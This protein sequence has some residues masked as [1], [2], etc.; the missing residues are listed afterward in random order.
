MRFQ[1]TPTPPAHPRSLPAVVLPLAQAN[2]T[3]IEAQNRPAK[4]PF[5]TINGFHCVG[6]QPCVC[7]LPPPSGWGWQTSAAKGASG[8]PSLT[9][10][11]SRPAGP[12]RLTLRTELLAGPSLDG[13]EEVLVVHSTPHSTR[14]HP[15]HRARN[16]GRVNFVSPGNLLPPAEPSLLQLRQTN[17]C[18]VFLQYHE[19]T[20][21]VDLC[22]PF[23]LLASCAKSSHHLPHEGAS[24][25]LPGRFSRATGM[26]SGEDPG[27]PAG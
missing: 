7:R 15:F 12:V 25:R 16:R 6:T 21:A 3:E 27:S 22:D 24:R 8:T 9:K 20:P 2:A 13:T 11:S 10:A 19:S 26:G 5:W 1:A 23:G 14:W 17:F 4:S 18:A